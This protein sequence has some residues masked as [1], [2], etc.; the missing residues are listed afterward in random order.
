MGRNL[1]SKCKLC[2]REGMKLFLKGNRCSMEKCAFAKR[3]TP[4]GMHTR[5]SSKPS[6]Y[7]LQLREK[8]RAKWMYGMLEKQFRRFF[9]VATKTKGATGRAL[10][11]MLERRVDNV[12]F[13]SL[14]TTSREAARQMVLHGFVLVNG[15]RVNIPS[16][17]VS[18][19]E[20]IEIK[21]K[22][23]TKK[24]LKETYDANAKERS[25]VA[26]LSVDKDALSAKILRLPEKED[27]V[28]PIN[29][30]LIVELYSK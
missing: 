28:L 21:A 5:V 30:Q 14:F 7:A 8:Q 22:D 23:N 6:Y 15:K 24:A 3:P 26:W 9:H 2:R 4:P 16:F 10:L 11:Q 13:R 20:T 12:I 19:G 27:I 1:G 18:A 29:E 17:L 25:I